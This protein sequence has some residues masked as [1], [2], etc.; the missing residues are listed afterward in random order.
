MGASSEADRPPVSTPSTLRIRCSLLRAA[1]PS[2][3]VI[4]ARPVT[5]T[6]QK[7]AQP[8]ASRASLA[9]AC[10]AVHRCH[11]RNEACQG[12]TGCVLHTRDPAYACSHDSIEGKT[13]KS[14][15]RAPPLRS[16]LAVAS[17]AFELEL[18][19]MFSSTGLSFHGHVPRR[20][21]GVGATKNFVAET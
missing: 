20:C 2:A 15:G 1:R 14:Q 7:A 17:A 4:H 16:C 10:L 12:L 13:N 8:T 3:Y 19:A 21:N 9:T 5:R 11:P 18:P 6:T